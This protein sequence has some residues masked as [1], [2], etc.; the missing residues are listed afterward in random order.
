MIL[1]VAVTHPIPILSTKSLPKNEALQ[2][3]REANLYFQKKEI[4]YLTLSKA[5]SL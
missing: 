5:S 1:D 4:K 3:N 2:P